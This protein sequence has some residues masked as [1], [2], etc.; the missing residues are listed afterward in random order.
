[1]LH[2]RSWCVVEVLTAGELAEKLTEYSWTLCG[3]FRLG[4]Y[5]YL[6]DSFSECSAV[7]FGVVKEVERG[8]WVQV[9]TITFGWLNQARAL[10]TIHDIR[11]GNRDSVWAE[12]IN[13]PMIQTPE[14]HKICA[15][16][17]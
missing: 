3:G 13:A 9:D 8:S 5:V 12:K 16:C 6:N 10:E 2:K 17:A 11:N 7:E 15:L 1:M 4:Q 14:E